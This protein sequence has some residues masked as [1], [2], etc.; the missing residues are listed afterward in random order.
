MA[1]ESLPMRPLTT[2]ELLDAAVAVLRRRPIRLLGL[3]LVLAA[4]EQAVLYPIRKH[5][6]AGVPRL[7]DVHDYAHVIIA[8]GGSAQLW[9]VLALGMAFEATIIALIGAVA[10]VPALDLLIGDLPGASAILA[11]R[12]RPVATIVLSI[13]IGS[14]A[15]LTFVVGGV[16]WV[17]W[18]MLTGLATPT[19]RTDTYQP[20][21]A[22]PR[23][24][25]ILRAF[26]RGF[27]L[28]ARMGLRAGRVR[29]MGYAIWFAIRFLIAYVGPSA[30]LDTLTVSGH[31]VSTVVTYILWT[32][33]NALAYTAMGCLDAVLHLETRMRVEGLD[34][35]L[36][37]ALR[38]KLPVSTALAV[39]R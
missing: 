14:G 8:G 11:S 21:G 38:R 29:V 1:T 31:G 37:R 16:P 28:S 34:I 17:L 4:A 30:L 18:F 22:A 7:G 12:A 6:F 15:F 20:A 25:G 26:G 32:G 35:V 23:R 2:G 27:G 36:S 19:L 39:P 33:I 3:G 5:L 10:A 24:I 13:V 9:F